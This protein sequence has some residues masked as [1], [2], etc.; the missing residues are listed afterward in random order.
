M[1]AGS[2]GIVSIYPAADA[3]DQLEIASSLVHETGH[4]ASRAA[5]GNPHD[6]ANKRWDPWRQAMRSDGMA[7]STYGKSSESEDFA[8]S[9]RLYAPVV[10]K[11]GAYEARK[12]I[13]ARCRLMDTLLDQRPGPQPR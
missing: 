8:E 9:W 3:H 4:T 7:L 10:G 1:S 2:N 13:P 6:Q 11:P 5:W 12:L